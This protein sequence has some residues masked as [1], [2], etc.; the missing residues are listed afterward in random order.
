MQVTY[1]SDWIK[2]FWNVSRVF[3]L[4]AICCCNGNYVPVTWATSGC[5]VSHADY[6]NHIPMSCRMPL[7]RDA[8]LRPWWCES[9]VPVT[10]ATSSCNVSHAD[11]VNHIPMSCRTPLLRDAD[12][13][14]WCCESHVPVT[15]ATSSCNVSHADYVNHIPMSCRTPLLRDAD[16]RPWWCESHVPVTRV[17]PSAAWLCHCCTTQEAGVKT[18]LGVPCWHRRV[19]GHPFFSYP[20]VAIVK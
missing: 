11:Y 9:H 1:S 19:V 18:R 10:W 2:F 6:V 20:A 17:T 4:W 3:P 15:W 13:R 14:P 7:L 12:L 8:D 5:N 16:L